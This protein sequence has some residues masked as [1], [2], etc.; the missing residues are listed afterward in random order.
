MAEFWWGASPKTEIRHHGHYYPSCKGKCGPI[1]H[2]MLQ[3]LQVEENPMLKKL[4]T[5]AEA[6][7][8]LFE[9]PWLV[10]INKPAGL[11]SVPGKEEGADSVVRPRCSTT[12][13]QVN[14]FITEASS[15]NGST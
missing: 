10:V 9:D 13:A 5:P 11:L 12:A 6:L 3:G 8:T 7:E 4:Q 14:E 1:L 15:I 2:H